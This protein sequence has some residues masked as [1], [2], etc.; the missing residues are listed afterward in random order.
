[1]AESQASKRARAN[2]AGDTHAF[3]VGDEVPGSA[4]RQIPTEE[5]SRKIR[6]YVQKLNPQNI[7]DILIRA[8]ETHPDVS[9]MVSHAVQKLYEKEQSRVIDFDRY[10]K[11]VWKSI[12]I[13]Y[14]SMSGSKQYEMAFDVAEEVTSTIRY[15]A[16][17]SG[18]FANPKTRFNGLSV[19]RKIG[20]T[21][22]LSS[23][24]TLGHEVQKQF[25]WD[26]CLE[27]GMLKI[28]SAM[29]PEERRAIRVDKSGPEAL[30]PKLLELKDLG[31]GYCLFEKL[32]EVLD[33]LEGKKGVDREF[34]DDE[35]DD[36]DDEDDDDEDDE[37]DEDD[38]D[39]EEDG[40]DGEDEGWEGMGKYINLDD[41]DSD[42]APR[43]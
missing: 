34:E 2:T 10:S 22:A 8:A 26:P 20:K 11:S 3:P 12:N 41:F 40:E 39:D 23:T 6:Q 13:T 27:E 9:A 21:I 1:M 29:K 24:D 35:D 38:E 43:R 16:K 37:G 17:Q 33:L 28:V 4:A 15:I 14:R 19:L 7:S 5:K 18:S 42:G 30:W 32:G 31:K 25:Q 36:E